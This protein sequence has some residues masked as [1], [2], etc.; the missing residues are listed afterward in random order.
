METRTKWRYCGSA[1][2]AA[3][4]LALCGA[5]MAVPVGGKLPDA[6]IYAGTNGTAEAGDQDPNTPPD[7]KKYPKD[8]RCKAKN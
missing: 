7:C 5:A 4:A 2:T 6:V 1:T 8:S 3:M